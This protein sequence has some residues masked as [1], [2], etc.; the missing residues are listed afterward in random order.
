MKKKTISLLLTAAMIAAMGLTACAE[1]VNYA[2][3][4]AVTHR[5]RLYRSGCSWP[6]LW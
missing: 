1:E 5:G 4:E 6:D 3:L 2:D